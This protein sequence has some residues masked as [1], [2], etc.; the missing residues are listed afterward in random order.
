[1]F[2]FWFVNIMEDIICNP[3]LQHIVEKSLMCLDR[4]SIA[5]FR[6]VNLDCRRITDCLKFYFKKL[7]QENP[8]Q[9]FVEVWESL[10]QKITDEDIKQRLAMQFFKMLCTRSPKAPLELAQNLAIAR[11]EEDTELVMWIIE[12]SNPF[13]YVKV[14]RNNA[15]PPFFSYLDY[16]PMH[17]AAA[18][19]YIQS[20]RRMICK[21]VPPNMRVTPMHV[22]AYNN[23]LEVVQLLIASSDNPNYQD[24]IG[25]TPTYLAAAQGHLEVVRSLMTTTNNPNAPNEY[26]GT[27][28]R[29]A[30]LNGYLEIVRLLMTSTN[31]PNAPN[32]FGVTPE[33]FATRNGHH[34]IA[35]LLKK[36]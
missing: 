25:Q 13:S 5:E 6:L 26:G 22:A 24:T 20:A 10:I 36:T 11:K 12:N 16:S 34:D 7:A 4:K 15:L 29:E 14:E 30:A 35:E 31:N 18:F 32:I 27:P 9:E 2:D 3:G 8:K 28:I 19:G 33:A 17:L 21:S 1:M 23:H